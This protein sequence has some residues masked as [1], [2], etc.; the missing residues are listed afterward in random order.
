MGG[1][2]PAIATPP[3]KASSYEST[4]T[5]R[6]VACR[7]PSASRC[8]RVTSPSTTTSSSSAD[9][10]SLAAAAVAAACASRSAFSLR[11]RSRRSA[12]NAS[13]R[14]LSAARDAARFLPRP[15][16][17]ATS[18]W[19]MLFVFCGLLLLLMNYVWVTC[20]VGLI[21]PA[22]SCTHFYQTA[23]MFAPGTLLPNC[24]ETAPLLPYPDTMTST[25]RLCYKYVVCLVK[26]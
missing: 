16:L 7:R 10:L 12:R 25:W 17:L 2:A 4:S 11:S 24:S 8:S 1:S 21:P 3:P 23:T 20:L 5:S 15:P 19:P 13:R 18:V 9:G 22:W 6:S 26:S 14:A